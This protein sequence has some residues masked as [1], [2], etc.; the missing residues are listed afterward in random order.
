MKRWRH[1][2]AGQ[3]VAQASHE[4]RYLMI[5]LTGASVFGVYVILKPF[6]HSIILALLLVSIFAPVHQRI[7]QRLGQ[8]ENIAAF[9]AVL[10]VFL[11]VLIPLSLFLSGLVR[12]GIDSI[13]KTNAWFAEGKFQEAFSSERVQSLL[14]NKRIE[15]LRELAAPYL[16]GVEGRPADIG[17]MALKGGQ[18]ALELVQKGVVPL[19]QAGGS[20]IFGFFIML[21]VMFF[22]FRDGATM[23]ASVLHLSP[24]STSQESALIGRIREVS[25]AVFLGTFITAAAQAVAAMVGFK[26]VGIPALFWGAMLGATSLVP[27]VGTALVWVPAVGY[28]LI[29]GHSGL[30]IFLTLWC[31]LVVGSID[32]FLRPI[33]MGGRVGM[34]TVVIFFAILGGIRCF[35]SPVGI[36]YGPLIFGLCAVCFYIYELENASFLALQDK[37]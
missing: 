18:K 5:A 25:R 32:N 36:I 37:R 9:L 10:V 4:A 8:R 3:D 20:V 21:F 16:G 11:L 24:L 15:R 7:R 12:Q 33:L 26:I 34:S 6:L 17:A 19:L 29:T 23:L 30:A 31:L 13:Q 28:L 22:A 14:A 1:K 27:M 35:R 2:Q